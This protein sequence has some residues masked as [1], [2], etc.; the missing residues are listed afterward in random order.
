[1]LSALE[2]FENTA[3]I[4]RRYKTENHKTIFIFQI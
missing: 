1:M 3:F 2:V 4:K